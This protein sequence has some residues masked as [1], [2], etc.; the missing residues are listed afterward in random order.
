MNNLLNFYVYAYLRDRSSSSS[1]VGT[2]YYIGKGCYNRMFNKHYT[3]PKDKNFIVILESNLTELGAFALE[4]RYI[5]WYGRKD[6]GTGILNNQTDGGEGVSGRIA[7][8]ETRKKMSLA[9]KGKP[10][11]DEHR[12]KCSVAAKGYKHT[13]ETRRK[14]S[15]IHSEYRHTDESK[16]KMSRSQKGKPRFHKT[17][18]I[19]TG[20]LK[21]MR[22]VK[23]P[24]GNFIS[25]AAA[26]RHHGITK[27]AVGKCCKSEKYIDWNYV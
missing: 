8:P 9:S 2:P 14:M 11:S 3:M 1:A 12:K 23:T 26:G 17:R 19:P 27:G 16:L 22:P 18:G 13:E 7:S 25:C 6:L 24:A 20:P 10:K 4:R 5:K 15:E 21:S